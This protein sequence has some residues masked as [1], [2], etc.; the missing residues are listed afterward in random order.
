MYLRLTYL[1]RCGC[2]VFPSIDY[3]PLLPKTVVNK[4]FLVNGYFHQPSIK[5]VKRQALLHTLKNDKWFDEGYYEIGRQPA[6]S[7]QL[8]L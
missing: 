3:R 6:S 4:G 2:T 1:C 8:I 5:V 7:N